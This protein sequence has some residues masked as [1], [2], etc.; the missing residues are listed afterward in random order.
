MITSPTSFSSKPSVKSG[1]GLVGRGGF[2]GLNAPAGT[3]YA[4]M[5]IDSTKPPAQAFASAS[6]G[7]GFQPSP[8]AASSFKPQG[9]MNYSAYGTFQQPQYISDSSTQSVMNNQLAQGD[10]A[11]DLRG[12]LKNYVQGGRSL[13][14]GERYRAALE[15]ANTQQNARFDAAQTAMN[16]AA[17][18]SKMR[19]DYEYA[20]EM[21]GQNLGALQAMLGQA[22]WADRF[23]MQQSAAQR[24]AQ[25]QQAALQVLAP[26]YAMYS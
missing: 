19:T 15:S 22:N 7:T 6:G 3:P 23:S 14:R 18:N 5:G 10:A 13:G 26:L 24:L 1:G 4:G 16:D 11:A 17:Q 2:G 8:F 12:L 20:R 9:G 21:E 25:M